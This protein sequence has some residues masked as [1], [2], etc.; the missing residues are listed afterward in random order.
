MNKLFISM[1]KSLCDYTLSY[2]FKFYAKSS[3][4]CKHKARWKLM[5]AMSI[6]TERGCLLS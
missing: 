3:S 4:L 6:P 1:E 2:V 5:A